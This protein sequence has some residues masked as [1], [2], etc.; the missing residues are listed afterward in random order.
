MSEQ[1][2][3]TAAPPTPVDTDTV[4]RIARQ[5]HAL[6]E[7]RDR[8]RHAQEAVTAALRAYREAAKEAVRAEFAANPSPDRALR[9]LIGAANRCS[10]T[11]SGGTAGASNVIETVLREAALDLLAD[12]IGQEQARSGAR[13]FPDC[14]TRP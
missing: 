11:W 5:Q 1:T 10:A 7:A 14:Q 4:S 13:P 9:D 3:A 2:A 8:L 6:F 12:P